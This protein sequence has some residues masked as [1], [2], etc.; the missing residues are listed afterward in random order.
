MD[1]LSDGRASVAEWNFAASPPINSVRPA[2]DAQKV[3]INS[4]TIRLGR[5]LRIFEA[6]RAFQYVAL[7]F[8]R[9]VETAVRNAYL[10]QERV[11]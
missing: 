9:I 4:A 5:A 2:W 3:R 6:E 7:A 10:I 8:E 11:H 1:A